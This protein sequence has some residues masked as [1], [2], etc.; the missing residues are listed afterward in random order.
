MDS[1]P[2]TLLILM[3][4]TVLPEVLALLVSST[5][6]KRKFLLEGACFVCLIVNDSYENR[7]RKN[8][9]KSE[10]P[11]PFEHAKILKAT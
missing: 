9:A 4:R 1:Y 11:L 2:L 6:K 10:Y 3:R 5:S 7:L 8:V